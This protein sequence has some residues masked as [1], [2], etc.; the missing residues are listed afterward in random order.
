MGTL[1]AAIEHNSD[2]NQDNR[3][4]VVKR[5]TAVLVNSSEVASGVKNKIQSLSKDEPEDIH[6]SQ[7]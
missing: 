3:K 4:P 1:Q 7:S 2:V 6:N 5:Q